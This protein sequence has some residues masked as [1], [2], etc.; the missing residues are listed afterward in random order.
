MLK[1]TNLTI[2]KLGKAKK[3]VNEKDELAGAVVVFTG[4]E[5]SLLEDALDEDLDE[6]EE[7]AQLRNES[8]DI[9]NF[10]E[11]HKEE[12]TEE[13]FSTWQN[14]SSIVNSTANYETESNQATDSKH[15]VTNNTE[16]KSIQSYDNEDEKIDEEVDDE[17]FFEVEE[18]ELAPEE[19]VRQELL[20]I[21]KE[22]HDAK[23]RA[24]A[25]EEERKRKFAELK[26]RK[27]EFKIS[28]KKRL[29]REKL[30]REEEARVKAEARRKELEALR[31][32]EVEAKRERKLREMEEQKALREQIMRK[33]V[34]EETARQD[35]MRRREEEKRVRE[36]EKAEREAARRSALEKSG[37]QS[38]RDM[39]RSLSKRPQYHGEEGEGEDASTSKRA[40]YRGGEE[41]W[42][43]SSKEASWKPNHQTKRPQQTNER[44]ENL[45]G[46]NMYGEE[47]E[48]QEVEQG[49]VHTLFPP[50]I[51]IY[52]SMPPSLVTGPRLAP[53]PSWSGPEPKQAP[54]PPSRAGQGV[55]PKKGKKKAEKQPVPILPSLPRALPGIAI[56]KVRQF[57][58][59][60]SFIFLT[61]IFQVIPPPPPPPAPPRPN[62]M[63]SAQIARITK[64]MALSVSLSKPWL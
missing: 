12:Q 60:T 61:N 31:L 59:F 27:E 40:R 41:E 64:N 46:Y 11:L 3:D 34:E 13:T 52:A 24:K 45:M 47:E 8:E 39:Q 28:E 6:S 2:Q 1:L 51:P 42:V 63:A 37:K 25:E 50:I 54:G 19:R 22:L 43:E 48:I 9:E 18:E 53:G 5:A 32:Q 55:G 33:K 10:I 36:E 29:E 57:S 15:M 20:A 23:V 4:A 35:E 16:L 44:D 62:L 21:E 26:Q 14:S 7:E 58:T 30:A 17:N 49:K 38:R 56:S